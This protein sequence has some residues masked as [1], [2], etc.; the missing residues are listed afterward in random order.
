MIEKTLR[1]INH[2]N[3]ILILA[4]L[5]E[6]YK[7]F[8]SAKLDMIFF[9]KCT[10]SDFINGSRLKNIVTSY[11]GNELGSAVLNLNIDKAL[12]FDGRHFNV[13]HVPYYK[14]YDSKKNNEDIL[15]RTKKRSKKRVKRVQTI[16][17]NKTR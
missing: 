7:K 10:L 13:I 11:K 17:Q 16:V 15:K 2:N 6:N 5:P 9:K 1:L 4:G 8:I 14:K 3:N 12:L